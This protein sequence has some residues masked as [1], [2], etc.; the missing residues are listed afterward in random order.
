MRSIAKS[1]VVAQRETLGQKT[2]SLIQTACHCEEQ[3]DEAI[4]NKKEIAAPFG[5]AMTVTIII[6][7]I[8]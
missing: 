2:V 8:S 3:S 4:P 5:L 6:S 1:S 7:C